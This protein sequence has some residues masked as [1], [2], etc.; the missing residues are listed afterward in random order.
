MTIKEKLLVFGCEESY[1]FRGG[2]PFNAGEYGYL[3]STFPPTCQVM[4]GAIR[5]ALLK[6]HGVDFTDY[7]KN[8]Y[9]KICGGGIDVCHVLKAVGSSGS[10]QDIGMDL[11]G[12]CVVHQCENSIQ[13]LYPAPLDL[14]RLESESSPEKYSRL[15]PSLEPQ[16]TDRGP[17]YFP[18]GESRYKPL[19]DAWITESGLLSYLK[20]QEIQAEDIYWSKGDPQLEPNVFLARE[21]RIGIARDHIKRSAKDHMLYATEHVRLLAE[22]GLAV[23]VGNLPEATL[24]GT[25]KLGGEGR[26]S[27]LQTYETA[28]IS[29]KGICDAIEQG[30]GLWGDK[31]FRLILLTPARFT[32]GWLPDEFKKVEVKGATVWQGRLQGINCTLVTACMD[33]PLYIGGWDVANRRPKPRRAYVPAGSTYYFTTAGKIEEVIAAMYDKKIGLDREIGCGHVVVGRW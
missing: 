11:K 10:Y 4:Q 27:S 33:R 5:T 20:G 22:Y 14:V 2:Q 30:P 6:G 9:C 13:R 8:N 29:Q 3:P 26:I 21:K 18:V 23:R 19:G 1:F 24:S 16:I 31:G 32:T 25:V 17:I 15:K 28:P 7:N 12:P